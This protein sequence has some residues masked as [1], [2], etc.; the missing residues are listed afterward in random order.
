M[1]DAACLRA[2]AA[3]PDALRG[4]LSFEAARALSAHL[5]GCAECRAIE[6]RE[7]VLD[8]ALGRMPS[9][10]ASAELKARLRADMKPPAALSRLRSRPGLVTAAVGLVAVALGFAVVW[11]QHVSS[12]DA[13]LHEAVN[14]HLR[15]LYS[16]HAVEIE[17]G[18]I[19]QVK[20]WFEGKLDFAPVLEFEGDA[21]FSL[22]GGSVG[23]FVDRKA[24][25]FV[26]K[27]RLHVMTLFV[28]RADGL[29]WPYGSNKALGRLSATFARSRGFNA[30]IYRDGDLGYAL[31]SDASEA[32]LTQLGER[33]VHKP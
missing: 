19:H 11:W 23:Y 18:G 4:R 29:S 31:V 12:S 20:P 7:R 5:T 16:Q 15:V 24:A 27:H 3:L 1:T 14:D 26:F 9:H 30:L 25:V 13:L 21:D 28:F 33:I 32:T 10:A 6:Q 17:S 22:E 2:R 8:D